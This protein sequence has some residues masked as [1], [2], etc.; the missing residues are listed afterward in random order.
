MLQTAP[1]LR[2]TIVLLKFA[3][4]L[5]LVTILYNCVEGVIALWS[6][7]AAGRIA[8]VAFGTDSYIEVAATSMALWRLGI[9]DGEYAEAQLCSC[10]VCLFGLR[11]CKAV[12]C[13]A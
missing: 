12:C 11:T 4:L 13:I 1:Y 8:L 10:R 9:E 7:I 5:L 3:K 6:G 2:R